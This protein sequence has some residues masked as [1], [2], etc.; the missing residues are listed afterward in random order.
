MKQVGD[1][2]GSMVS[3]GKIKSKGES[4]VEPVGREISF[5]T[6]DEELMSGPINPSED[7]DLARDENLEE[8]EEGETQVDLV[9][10]EVSFDTPDEEL[11]SGSINPSEDDDLARE[12]TLDEVEN[13]DNQ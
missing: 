10:R 6:P 9:G 7:D 13:E 3:Q 4:Q 2:E 5:D 12:E 11:M 8:V 1:T